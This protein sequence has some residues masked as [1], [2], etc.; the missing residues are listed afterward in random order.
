M[1]AEAITL[2]RRALQPNGI[3][4]ATQRAAIERLENIRSRSR[5]PAGAPAAEQ[6]VRE[7]RDSAR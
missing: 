7:D 6:L 3:Q 4:P 5:L 2:L 1:S